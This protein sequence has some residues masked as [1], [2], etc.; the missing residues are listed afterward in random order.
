MIGGV[1]VK[2]VSKANINPMRVKMSVIF[3]LWGL[4]LL[5]A[6]QQL[7]RHAT[8]VGFNPWLNLSYMIAV[9]APLVITKKPRQMVPATVNVN[10]VR[11]GNFYQ[12][13][14]VL[15]AYMILKMIARIAQPQPITPLK[16]KQ[17]V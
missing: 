3:V 13:P 6:Q 14:R 11:K 15:R 2:L 17:V 1:I 8:K 9:V 12:T 4:L 5:L 16:V 10:R 7:A